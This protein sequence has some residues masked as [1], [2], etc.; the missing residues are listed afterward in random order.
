[1]LEGRYLV[2]GFNGTL[3]ALQIGAPAQFSVYS[4]AG[5][6]LSPD[7]IWV[8]SRLYAQTYVGGILLNLAGD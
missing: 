2:W 3:T 5:R 1:M 8:P 4:E 6:F 7:D